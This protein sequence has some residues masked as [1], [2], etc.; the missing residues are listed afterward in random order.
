VLMAIVEFTVL[1]SP[2]FPAFL[3]LWLNPLV[4]MLKI[5]PPYLPYQLMTL[6]HRAGI[7]GFIAIQQLS[8]LFPGVAGAQGTPQAEAAQARQLDK[9]EQMMRGI[10]VQT[11]K[12]LEFEMAPYATD[13]ASAREV[14]SRFREWL[15]QN[16]VR[17]DPEVRDRIGRAIQAKRAKPGQGS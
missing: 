16:T 1:S 15:I 4:T 8:P 12:L 9:L 14:K 6:L 2:E 7:S 5:R 3:T 10:T 11:S 17:S 13:E